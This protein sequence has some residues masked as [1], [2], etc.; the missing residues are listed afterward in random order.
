MLPELMYSCLERGTLPTVSTSKSFT[1]LTVGKAY[2]RINRLAIASN[3][4]NDIRPLAPAK[5]VT[6]VNAE[7]TGYRVFYNNA[8][9]CMP[10]DELAFT[11]YYK[12]QT[13]RPAVAKIEQEFA[14]K[15]VIY[16]VLFMPNAPYQIAL[17]TKVS[18]PKKYVASATVK[19][20]LWVV[21]G[22]DSVSYTYPIGL[23]D[24]RPKPV[25]EY[26]VSGASNVALDIAYNF[27]VE[28]KIYPTPL[29]S[30]L[31]IRDMYVQ[32]VSG[33]VKYSGK[34]F[35]DPRTNN[36]I[37]V[38]ARIVNNTGAT[39][40]VRHWGLPLSVLYEDNRHVS[41]V[42]VSVSFPDR[43][44]YNGQSYSYYLD[45]TIP[46]WAYGKVAIAHA[47][48]VYKGG[49]FIYGGGPLWQ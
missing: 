49:M 21:F 28:N 17:K 31:H 36:I 4:V 30:G 26:P 43:E 27:R 2:D 38:G 16:N 42:N 37:R 29:P 33:F 25:S 14:G 13:S 47:L 15:K 35:K 1:E 6:I 20:A 39:I 10:D 45:V 7:L 12:N 46:S 11:V 32:F 44:I 24:D 18:E 5:P 9:L 3:M 23:F 22:T 19:T 34:L 8:Y 40:V 48:K 41:Q